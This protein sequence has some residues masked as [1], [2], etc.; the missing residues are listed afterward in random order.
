MR[1]RRA[2]SDLTLD[3][4]ILQEA[5]RGS[6]EPGRTHEGHR[7]PVAHPADLRTAPSMG[8]TGPLGIA[9]TVLLGNAWARW[10]IRLLRPHPPCVAVDVGQLSW[11]LRH[12]P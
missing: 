12:L 5:A 7:R 4:L 2:V 11:T 1:S 10:F 3:K 6:S 8:A 9:G